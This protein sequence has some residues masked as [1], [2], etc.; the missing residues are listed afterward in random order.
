MK[1]VSFSLAAASFVFSFLS[2]PSLAQVSFV[3]PPTYPGGGSFTAD[4]N[5]D[6]KA[7][8]LSA[9]GTLLGNGDG[10]FKPG[11][12]VSGNPLAVADFDGDGKPDILEQGTGTLLV[13]LGNGDGTFQAPLSTPSGASLTAIVAADLNGDG[14]ADVIGLFNG[15][16]M[17]YLGK[18][19]GTFASGVPYSTGT[20]LGAV[21]T[22]GDFNGDHKTDVLVSTSPVT[23]AGQEIVFLGNGDGT[24]QPPVTSVGVNEP[25]SIAVGDFNGDGKVDLLINGESVTIGPSTIA[26]AT[27]LLLGNGDGTF[28]APASVFPG[29]GQVAALDLNGDGKLDVIFTSAPSVVEIHLGNGRWH[30]LEY[31]QLRSSPRRGRHRWKHDSDRRL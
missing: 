27:Y 13:L 1:R 25:G 17:V 14:K 21:V 26:A 22:V 4:F 11:T 23:S 24:F 12:P 20:T 5:G 7:D 16:L 15:M 28:Q 2:S 19:D 3:Q 8:L 30:V 29:V 10:T 9:N 6:G 18:G 31:Q